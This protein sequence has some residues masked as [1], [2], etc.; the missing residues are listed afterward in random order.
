MS[1]QGISRRELFRRGGELGTLLALPTL[2]PGDASAAVADTAA[3]T[4]G[5]SG[6]GLRAGPDV[7]QSIGVRP[8]INARGTYTIISGST[9]LPEVR[10]A[11][12]AAAQKYV[13]LDELTEA[14]GARLAVLTGAEWGLVSNGCAAGLTLATAAC[15]AGGSPDL[16]VR[17]PNL[18]GFP[19]DEVI[20]PTHS[21][22]VYD[23]ALRSVGVR[24]TE[25]S[26]MEE[27]EAVLGRRTAMIYILA[28]PAADASPLN[29]KA[30][31]PIAKAKAVPILVDAAA[32]I[33]TIPNVHLQNGAT[34]VAYSGGKCIRGPQTAGLLLGRKDLVR[35]AWVHSA[36][37]HGFAR[38]L[39][40]GKEDAIGMLMAVEMWVKRDHDA[41]WKRW[42]GWLDHIAQRVSTIDGVTTSV[43][44]PNGL[45]NRTP[46]L[47]VLW[48]RQKIALTGDA[49][50]R[51][52]FAGDPRI[53]LDPARG[54]AQPNL[55]GVSVTPYMLAPGEER[56]VGDKLHALLSKPSAQTE[57]K[58]AA[59]AAADLSGQW[60]VRIQYAA[61]MSNHV[62]H[63]TQKGSDLGGLHQGEFV[64]R[65]VTG[66]MEG[67][68]VRIRS[69]YG[70]QHGDSVNL[71]FSGKLAG[72]QMSGTLDMG[73]YLAATWTAT[74]RTNER[75]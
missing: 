31:A 62:L 32:E 56:I 17:I 9:M 51:A 73:E 66:T 24:V 61:G 65:E 55:T 3:Q 63:L 30:I 11:M 21:R 46:S 39:K 22:N 35:A 44:Q 40:V 28:G 48:D 72:D 75:G 27:F 69:A 47:R 14:V 71:T 26:T 5:T 43:V 15:V 58:P 74:R 54:Q 38:S 67:D 33:L 7:Y 68:T 16:H 52:L 13:H 50:A 29:V 42:T 1:D 49:A 18:A 6:L 8:L 20:I 53:V 45:S 57:T 10:A 36:P 2:M 41:E 60:N 34:L 12:D 64:T 4:T 19:R 25:V 23:A 37:H 59:S 70:E